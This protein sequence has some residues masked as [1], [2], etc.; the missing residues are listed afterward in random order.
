[1]ARGLH[2]IAAAAQALHRDFVVYPRHHDLAGACLARAVHRQQVAIEYTGVA[3]AHSA[4]FQQVV[5]AR[6]KQRRI[7]LAAPLD[8]LLG[9]DRAACRD[10][11]D[12]GLDTIPAFE[13]NLD[14]FRIN[15]AGG[16]FCG[17][18]QIFAAVD[19]FINEKKLSGPS[20]A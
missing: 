5:G 13:R 3:H 17:N 18:T 15:I 10:A 9:E 20:N 12:Q 6:L 16:Q 1:M 8:V 14:A 4:D 11:A 2:D 7:D 19:R